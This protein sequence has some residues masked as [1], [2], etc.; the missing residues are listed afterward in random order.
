MV[1]LSTVYGP[2]PINNKMIFFYEH[3]IHFDDHAI[4]YLEEKTSNSLV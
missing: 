3:V 1:Q 2:S 4:S